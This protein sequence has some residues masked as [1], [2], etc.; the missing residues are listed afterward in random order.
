MRIQEKN[1]FIVLFIPIIG[2]IISGI[3]GIAGTNNAAL[4]PLS[5]IILIGSYIYPL[6]IKIK[7]VNEIN[8]ICENDGNKTMHYLLMCLFS[9][10]TFGIVYLVYV[11]RLQNRLYQNAEE[12]GA[13][14]TVTGGTIVLCKLLSLVT[15]GASGIVAESIILKSFNDIAYGYNNGKA[16][17][18]P[19]NK[20]SGLMK[21]IEGSLKGAAVKMNDGEPI[22]IGTS[23]ADASFVLT[24]RTVS[25]KHCEIVYLAS[26]DKYSVTDF[27]TNG[28][29]LADGTR[30]PKNIPYNVDRYSVLVLS[31]NSKLQLN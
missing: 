24:D 8:L 22:V 29:R 1:I 2:G 9:I 25:R 6:V 28:T 4:I 14:V 7:M 17:P 13:R 31:E 30:L 16:L 18:E 11:Y 23:A 20:D 3:T 10:L 26:I 19:E 5:V 21:C 27:S 12:Y 15:A